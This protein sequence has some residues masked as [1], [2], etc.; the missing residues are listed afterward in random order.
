M[1]KLLKEK[2]ILPAWELIKEDTKIKKF[3][4]L[5]WLLSILFLTILLLYQAIYTYVVLLWKTD[6]ALVII[7]KFFQSDYIVEIII[8]SII[9]LIIYFLLTPI[10]EWW[11]IKYIDCINKDKKIS[12]SEAFWQWLYNFFPIF[13]YNNL[14]SEF[15]LISILNWFLFT[16]RFIW[17]EY[18]KPITYIFIVLLFLWI[19]L[20]ILFA[21]SKYVIIIDKEPV[22]KAI[23]ISSKISILN[24]KRTTKLYFLMLLLNMRV[25]FNFIIFLSFP[26][27]IIVVI[28]L[29]TTKIFLFVAITILTILFIIFILGIWYLT[30]VLEVF[31]TAIWYYAYI[32]GKKLLEDEL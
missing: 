31:T 18:I 32:E 5:P 2:I 29:I 30:A 10:F 6:E 19:L 25:I 20:N 23:W 28:W 7:L 15:K 8:S 27:I 13:E 14:F 26:L 1:A 16:L 21:Y 11:L 17:V 22:F 3:Y 12:T 9:F 24:I 4:I